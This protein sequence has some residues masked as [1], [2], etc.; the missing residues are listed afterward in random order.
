MFVERLMSLL[1]EQKI[2][3]SKMLSELGLGKNQITYWKKNGNI[4]SATTV[5]R[6]AK[7]LDVSVDYLLGKTEIKKDLPGV[8]PVG[9]LVSLRIVASVRAGFGNTAIANWD[10]EYETIPSFMLHGYPAEECVLF[11]VKGNSMYPKI[12]DGDKIIVHEQSSVDSG[13][14]AIV[15]Y[16]DDEGTVKKVNYVYGEEWLELIPA[17]PEYPV[18]RIEGAELEKCHVFGKVI[19]LFRENV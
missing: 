12:L 13:D 14:T 18:K 5:E 2:T 8:M 4:P 19:G 7:Y 3:S 10:G 15:V 11:K 9:D 6:I 1:K 17:N 16:N